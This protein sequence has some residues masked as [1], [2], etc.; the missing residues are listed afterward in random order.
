[1]LK[2]VKLEA[3]GQGMKL[4]ANTGE[5]SLLTDEP[6]NIGG[7]N[8]AATPL[9]MVLTSLLG[10]EQATAQF[11][12]QKKKLQINSIEYTIQ[13]TYDMRGMLGKDNVSPKFQ[14]VDI[15]AKLDTNMD[16][17]QINSLQEQVHAMCPV[18]ALFKEAGVEMNN[19]WTRK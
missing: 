7:T 19:Q 14:T 6:T 13:G 1:M 8:T 9:H 3:L 10:C 4:M 15:V 16:Q 17:T 11:I 12:A 5:H 18:V 2:T